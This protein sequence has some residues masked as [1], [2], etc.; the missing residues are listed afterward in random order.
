MLLWS[1]NAFPQLGVPLISVKPL[2]TENTK[3]K[4]TPKICKI[5][6]VLPINP[7]QGRLF[8]SSGGQGGGGGGTKCPP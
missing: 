5:T 8:W 2:T 3:K 4:T 1:L 7:I 6:V